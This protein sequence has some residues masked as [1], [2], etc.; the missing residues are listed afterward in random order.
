MSPLLKKEI[1]LRN[2]LY[3][4]FLL[5]IA[6]LFVAYAIFQARFLLQ[7]PIVT[8]NNPPSPVQ[9][10][11]LITIK[12]SAQNIVKMTLNGRQIYTDKDG[13]FKEALIL[14]NGYTITTIRVYDRYGHNR[15]Y[16]QKFVYTPHPS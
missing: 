9:N 11:R 2:I 7:G 12:G 1:S 6:G 15:S 5:I 10:K 14:E 13:N 3:Y 16:V 4:S 8:F